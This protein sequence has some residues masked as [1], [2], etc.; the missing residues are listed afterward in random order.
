MNVSDLRFRVGTALGSAFGMKLYESRMMI[1]KVPAGRLRVGPPV[2]GRRDAA[3]ER[4][5]AVA[6]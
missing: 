1:V 5:P 6:G 3:T 2:S 4:G